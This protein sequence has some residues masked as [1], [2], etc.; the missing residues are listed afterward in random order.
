MSYIEL[1][2]VVIL[3]LGL[4]T[5]LI[6]YFLK[7]K[8]ALILKSKMES[9]EGYTSLSGNLKKILHARGKTLTPMNPSGI[10]EIEGV[11]FDAQSR[12]EYIEPGNEVEVIGFDSVT[13][14][15][16]LV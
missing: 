14:V 12:G 9:E 11:R 16:R 1:I 3:I 4:L 15:V 8:D 7:K 10:I 5:F 2:F 6:V 13:P